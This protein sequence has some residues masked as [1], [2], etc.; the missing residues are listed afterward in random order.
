MAEAGPVKKNVTVSLMRKTI[1]TIE[2][3]PITMLGFAPLK[4]RPDWHANEEDNP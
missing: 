3:R 2:L 1:S 4:E